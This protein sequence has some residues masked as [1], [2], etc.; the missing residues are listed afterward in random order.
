MSNVCKKLV[1]KRWQNEKSRP[2]NDR[3]GIYAIG[4]K[5]E[6]DGQDQEETIYVGRS[7]HIHKRLSQH[8]Q[9]SRRELQSINTFLQD[10]ENKAEYTFVVKWVFDKKQKQKEGEYLRCMTNYLKYRPRFNLKQ[11]DAP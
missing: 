10:P 1:T 11:G 6:E 5:W 7:K 4:I 9:P 2:R 8:F 3:P